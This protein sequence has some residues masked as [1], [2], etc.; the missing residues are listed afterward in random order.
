MRENGKLV[1]KIRELVGESKYQ[2]IVE[3]IDSLLEIERFQIDIKTTSSLH[4][5]FQKISKLLDQ[6]FQVK[7]FKITQVINGIETVRHLQINNHE[8]EFTSNV[9]VAL[10]ENGLIRIDFYN[11]HLEDIEKLQL[12]SYLEETLT[13]LYLSII[14]DAL[15]ESALLDPLTGLKNRLAF[16]EEMKNIIP[17]ALREQMNIGVLLF[18]ID[19]F[20]AVNDE[21]GTQF[22]DKF[23]KHYASIIQNNIRSSDIAIRFGGGEFLVLLINIVDEEKTYAL[24]KDLQQKLNE[25]YILS[26]NFDDFYKTVSVGIA[27]FPQ[28]SND[29]F[30]VVHNASSALSDARDTGRSQIVR[31]EHDE[32]ELDLF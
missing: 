15:Q 24:A 2:E 29:I 14:V 9:E 13:T 22:G 31:Y 8:K 20:R 16:N 5:K 10:N 12:D 11:E 26:P 7:N 3:I 23:L 17:L 19:R 30:E 6:K 32:G 4:L 25:S 27:M 18:N 21:H 1:S 28:D